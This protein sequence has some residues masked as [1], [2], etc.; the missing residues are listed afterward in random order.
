MSLIEA[1]LKYKFYF[2][3][4]KYHVTD[5]KET[6][7]RATNITVDSVSIYFQE[8]KVGIKQ[9]RTI[10]MLILLTKMKLIKVWRKMVANKSKTRANKMKCVRL[11]KQAHL[12]SII[13]HYSPLCLGNIHIINW[14]RTNFLTPTALGW[15]Q[16]HC[17]L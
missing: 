4:L 2:K 8:K 13:Y 11:I 12:N 14:G 5:F 1:F 16:Y 15:K 17:Q 3:Y 9:K 10:V 7:T 6:K